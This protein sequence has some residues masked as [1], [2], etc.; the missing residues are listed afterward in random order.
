LKLGAGWELHLE[1][2]ALANCRLNPDAAAVHLA[3]LLGN[4]ET[5]TGAAFGLGVRAVDLMELLEDARLL[6]NGDTWPVS[7]TLTLK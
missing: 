4:G 7:V 6:I 2:C 1:G 5:E 3:D